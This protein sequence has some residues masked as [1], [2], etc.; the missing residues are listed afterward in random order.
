MSLID[1]STALG[2]DYLFR[3]HVGQRVR[4]RPWSVIGEKRGAE[5]PMS[6]PTHMMYLCGTC[7]TVRDVMRDIILL[8]DFEVPGG[9][10]HKYS[11]QMVEPIDEQEEYLR[12]P[13]IQSA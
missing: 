3:P 12:L 13:G 1:Q 9:L 2:Q 10:A 11:R 8:K 5:V 6:F 4:F 7:A